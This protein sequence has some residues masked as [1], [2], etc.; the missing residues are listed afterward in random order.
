MQTTPTIKKVKSTITKTDFLNAFELFYKNYDINIFWK[1]GNTLDAAVNA[2]KAARKLW[3]NDTDFQSEFENKYLYPILS[4]ASTVFD[5]D[6]GGTNWADDYGWWG[7]A[8]TSA[9]NYCTASK[10]K[11][12]SQMAD[13]FKTIAE[14]AYTIMVKKGYVLSAADGCRNSGF[15]T[16]KKGAKNT[17]TNSNLFLISIRLYQ[18]TKDQQYLKMAYA[19][20]SWFHKYISATVNDDGS[21]GAYP[22]LQK[23]TKDTGLITE[24]PFPTATY[25]A[26]KHPLWE[27]GWAWTGDQGLFLACLTSVSDLADDFETASQD[28]STDNP[29]SGF[30][31]TSFNKTVNNYLTTLVNGIKTLL[32]DSDKIMHEPPFSSSFGASYG[33]DYAG[34]K[35]VLMRFLAT[36]SQSIVDFSDYINASANA[37]WGSRNTNTNAIPAIW[38]TSNQAT[39][40]STFAK[41]WGYPSANEASSNTIWGGYSGYDISTAVLQAAGLDAL[42]ASIAIS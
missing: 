30:D 3:D 17:V 12:I 32:F 5:A 4:A 8:A 40:N 24:R 25:N 22:Y 16:D 21:N 26:K 36:S 29:F 18:I 37:A 20:Y 28:N 6:K 15:A 31:K 14:E 9:Y 13:T 42:G 39:F 27:K 23:T 41:T 35:G 1:R 10:N 11:K 33:S 38:N 34:G 2:S 7:I 19:Q